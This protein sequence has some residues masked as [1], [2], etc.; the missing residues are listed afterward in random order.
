MPFSPPLILRVT[1][2]TELR[3]A[4]S[5]SFQYQTAALTDKSKLLATSSGSM[6]LPNHF[7]N[8]A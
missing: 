3:S 6:S 4:N 7:L 8:A 1:F 5:Q 2:S